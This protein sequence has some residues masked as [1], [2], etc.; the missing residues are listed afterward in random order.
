MKLLIIF[1]VTCTVLLSHSIINGC[2]YESGVSLR[3]EDNKSYKISYSPYLLTTRICWIKQPTNK[4]K[5]G[6][7]WAHSRKIKGFKILKTR[8]DTL[9]AVISPYTEVCCICVYGCTIEI[10]TIGEINAGNGKTI[11]IKN[12]TVFLE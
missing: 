4:T 6:V 12:G 3:N 9:I 11:V 10:E 5:N 1:L 2:E 8:S 7:E